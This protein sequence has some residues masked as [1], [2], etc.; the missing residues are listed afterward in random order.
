VNLNAL[1]DD[2]AFMYPSLATC[3]R[4]IITC[5][6]WRKRWLRVNLPSC[7]LTLR[8]CMNRKCLA[9]VCLRYWRWSGRSRIASLGQWKDLMNHTIELRQ[10]LAIFVKDKYNDIA[11]KFILEGY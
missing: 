8:K 9:R 5:P 4:G 3:R 1:V 10:L 2:T 6:T 7:P 11:S